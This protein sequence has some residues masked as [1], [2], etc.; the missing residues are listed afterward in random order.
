MPASLEAGSPEDDIEI[1][2]ER[3]FLADCDGGQCRMNHAMAANSAS[4][5]EAHS[6]GDAVSLA[7]VRWNK[8]NYIGKLLPF[9]LA[10]IDLM[11]VMRC[12]R[13][14]LLTGNPFADLLVAG[15]VRA[16][17]LGPRFLDEQLRYVYHLLQSIDVC[18]HVLHSPAWTRQRLCSR[19]VLWLTR[20]LGLLVTPP[21]RA[22]G[23]RGREWLSRE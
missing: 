10:R 2:G 5:Y 8:L 23:L 19:R 14:S 7:T 20:R 11:S 13:S 16:S 4:H 17:L 3:D 22:G 21:G 12:R 6:E 9:E 15:V 1:V 18:D